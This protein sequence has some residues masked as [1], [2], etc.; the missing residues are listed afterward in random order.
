MFIFFKN[1]FNK[2]IFFLNKK[3]Y[4]KFSFLMK[5]SLPFKFI[6]KQIIL[7][8]KVSKNFA[9]KIFNPKQIDTTKDQNSTENLL[10]DDIFSEEFKPTSSENLPNPAHESESS[11]INESEKEFKKLDKEKLRF[12]RETLLYQG[13]DAFPEKI[14]ERPEKGVVWGLGGE[15][16]KF[17]KNFFTKGEMPTVEEIIAFLEVYKKIIKYFKNQLEQGKDIT[18]VDLHELRRTDLP[19]YGI[20]VTTYSARHNYK[21]AKNLVKAL[22]QCEIPD[23]G[24]PPKVHGLK[25]DEWFNQLKEF[26][27]KILIQ[28]FSLL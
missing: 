17:K 11:L 7:S 13:D 9:R 6:F 19:K 5:L 2:I 28:G 18:L 25:T 20:L 3:N 22:I 14:V 24:S 4:L 23:Q 16:M 26:V 1:K 10:K 21:I 12:I 15:L 27:K 8:N